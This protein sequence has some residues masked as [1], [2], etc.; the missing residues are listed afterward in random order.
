VYL[1][2]AVEEVVNWFH[3]GVEGRQ[4]RKVAAMISFTVMPVAMT[5]LPSD[6]KREDHPWKASRLA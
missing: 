4:L 1:L 5:S 3:S 2:V 6:S